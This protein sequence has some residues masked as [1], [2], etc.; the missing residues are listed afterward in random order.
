MRKRKKRLRQDHKI[1]NLNTQSA[2]YPYTKHLPCIY[3]FEKELFTAAAV[4]QRQHVGAAGCHRL[5]SGLIG[6]F[7]LGI[8][9]TATGGIQICTGCTAH[10]CTRPWLRAW[11]QRTKKTKGQHLHETVLP[12]C[13]KRIAELQYRLPCKHDEKCAYANGFPIVAAG[14]DIIRTFYYERQYDVWVVW[15]M[16]AVPHPLIY[17]GICPFLPWHNSPFGPRPPHYRGFTT[18]LKH[19][20]LGRTPLDE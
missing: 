13:T 17:P 9:R 2:L 5:F 3:I 12:F 20:T 4:Q 7:V 15:R 6:L 1:N 10:T 11:S 19:T 14:L 8:L 16:L 18:A